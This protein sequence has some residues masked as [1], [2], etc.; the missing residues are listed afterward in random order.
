MLRT[1]GKVKR[2][3]LFRTDVRVIGEKH[4]SIEICY[5]TACMSLN[6]AGNANFIMIIFTAV[7]PHCKTERKGRQD[8][9]KHIFQSPEPLLSSGYHSEVGIILIHC[10]MYAH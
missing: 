2:K 7:W 8:Q 5:T 1:S 9:S 10:Y 4:C 6:V 3:P